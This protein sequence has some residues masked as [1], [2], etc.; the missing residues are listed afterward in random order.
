M[1]VS[2]REVLIRVACVLAITLTFICAGPLIQVVLVGVI[3]VC[4]DALSGATLATGWMTALTP[5]SVWSTIGPLAA[6]AGLTGLITGVCDAIFGRVNS[7]TMLVISLVLALV[8][9]IL[10][11]ISLPLA[12]DLYVHLHARVPDL[13][14]VWIF[15]AIQRLCFVASMMACWKLFD[16]VRGRPPTQTPAAG[17][18]APA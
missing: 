7:R 10:F 18:L 15:V 1:S 4:Y 14:A 17:S 11:I 9:L 2:N 3:S 5:R 12:I 13:N 16:V 8:S 6:G